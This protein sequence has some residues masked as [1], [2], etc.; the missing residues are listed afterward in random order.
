MK[1][2][3]LN[4]WQGERRDELKEFIEQQSPSTDIFC[5]QELSDEIKDDCDRILQNYQSYNSNK[6]LSAHDRFDQTTYVKNGISVISHETLLSEA[7]DCGLALY[8]EIQVGTNSIL[9]CN[10]HGMARPGDK[11]DSPG[12]VKQSKTLVD[13][14][15]TKPGLKIIGG[16]FNLSPD[17]KSVA[18]FKDAGY[19]NLISEFNI[20]TTRNHFTWDKYPDDK[21]YYADYVFVSEDVQV[22]SFQVP[23]NEISDHLPQLLEFSL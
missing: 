15:D 6:Y 18:I 21:Q 8:V 9:I 5:F 13:F 2:I 19:R 11:L 12:R 22:R 16:D 20:E 4:T 23:Q 10:V 14:F 7:T 3:F 17:T 1:I